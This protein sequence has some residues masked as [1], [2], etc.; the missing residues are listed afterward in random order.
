MPRWSQA[1]LRAM[2]R[3][4][5]DTLDTS[6]VLIRNGVSLPAQTVALRRLSG[7]ELPDGEV[8][9]TPGGALEI[10]GAF[11]LDIRSGDRFTWDGI[12]WK[13]TGLG[14]ATQTNTSVA[15][16]ALATS[17]GKASA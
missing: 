4:N 15:R 16:R 10:R 12:A 9:A 14:T 11:D 2:R 13:V 3:L 5:S 1:G 7:S 17:E 6:L 8:I